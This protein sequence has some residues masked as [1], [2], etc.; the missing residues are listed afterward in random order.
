MLADAAKSKIGYRG[1]YL[2]SKAT[3]RQRRC[4][5]GPSVRFTR[6]NRGDSS[7]ALVSASLRGDRTFYPQ[8]ASASGMI[9][10]FAAT[11]AIV[12]PKEFDRQDGKRLR[13]SHWCVGARPWKSVCTEATG[14]SR[15]VVTSCAIP[16]APE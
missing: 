1:S 16:S 11:A 14:L 5:V 13:R 9:C 15:V 4:R 12:F 2:V 10:R 8:S 3:I 7:P 6:S